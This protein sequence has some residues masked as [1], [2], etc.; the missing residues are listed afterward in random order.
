MYLSPQLYNSIV[1]G[2]FETKL[3]H[4]RKKLTMFF[5]DIAGFTEITD[6]IEPETLSTLLNEYLTIMSDIAVKYG[7]TIDKFIGDAIVIF[8]GDPEFRDDET[9]A[10]QCIRMAVE[11]LSRIRDLS[12]KWKDEGAPNGLSVRMGINSGFC[13][14]GN[15]GSE[16]RMDYTIVGSQVNIASRLEKIA[17]RN[18]IFISEATFSLVRDIIVVDE[19]RTLHVKGVHFPIKAY[20]ILGLKN[21]GEIVRSLL[22]RTKDGFILRSLTYDSTTSTEEYRASVISML[23]DALRYLR[24]E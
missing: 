4:S 23:E 8:F 21:Q 16:N 11:M 12:R 10:R 13:T 3:R 9:H 7:G 2:N 15:F 20:K 1:A 24:I 19:P 18:S 5:S 22:E 17:E 14:V 6:I